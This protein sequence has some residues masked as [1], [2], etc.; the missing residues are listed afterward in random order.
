MN[1]KTVCKLLFL[2]LIVSLPTHSTVMFAGNSYSDTSIGDPVNYGKENFPSDH[3]LIALSSEGSS[4]FSAR[5]DTISSAAE[6]PVPTPEQIRSWKNRELTRMFHGGKMEMPPLAS[7]QVEYQSD[8]PG[9]LVL[10]SRPYVQQN[11]DWFTIILFLGLVLFASVRHSFGHYTGNL[12]Q[13]LFNYSTASRM[14]RE[15]NVSLG[16][17]E[18]RLEVFSY[19]IFGLFF[20]QLSYFYNLNLPFT[21][22]LKYLLSLM[23]VLAFFLIKKLLYLVAGYMVEKMTETGEFLYN[24]SNH[25]RILGILALPIVALI[26]WAPFPTPYPLFFTGLTIVSLL[27]LILMWRGLKIFLKKQFSIFYLF[28]YLCTLEILPLLL[29]LK[30]VTG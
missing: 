28:L 24:F 16:Q 8:T 29:V 18:V 23:L 27:Y 7:T 26:A 12:F 13:S 19:F 3:Y 20:Y 6:R 25:I 21:G 1:R 14:Y 30:L 2:C 22:F 17:G 4:A 11:Q 15:R 10:P 5:I 9:W